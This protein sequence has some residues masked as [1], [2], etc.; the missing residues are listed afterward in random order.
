TVFPI[1]DGGYGYV[2]TELSYD[3]DRLFNASVPIISVYY[4]FLTPMT[5]QIS[6]K[7]L[8]HYARNV[9]EISYISCSLS[10]GELGNVCLITEIAERSHNNSLSITYQV[11]FLSSGSVIRLQPLYFQTMITNDRNYI[12]QSDI[13][14][15]FYG[16]SIVTNWAVDI[17]ND[18]TNSNNDTTNING[19]TTNSNDY[20]APINVNSQGNQVGSAALP[21]VNIT[22]DII[23]PN[24]SKIIGD[25]WQWSLI[26]NSPKY[27]VFFIMKNNTYIFCA[28]YEPRIWDIFVTNLPKFR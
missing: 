4:M 19:N 17:N 25:F 6:K 8:L 13:K 26:A 24:G 21:L 28:M 22:V 15:L 12:L 27:A 20:T 16:G 2:T 14:P 3:D 5:H 1:A 7:F 11:D 9:S 23:A 10:Y 18:T